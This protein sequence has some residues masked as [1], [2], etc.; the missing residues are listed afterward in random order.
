MKPRRARGLTL[1][2][3]VMVLAVLA[4]LG[5]VALPSLGARLQQQRLGTAAETLVADI[6][7]ARFEA[8][9]QGRAI[10]IVM[11]PGAGWCWSVATTATCPCGQAQA[12]EL[13]SA[14]VA[15]HAGVALVQARTLHLLST[16]QAESPGSAL[17][18]SSSGQQLRVDVQSLGRAR[19]CAARGSSNRYPPC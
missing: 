9:R 3:L 16:G 17:M 15:D 4:V 13:R 12:C 10:H 19:I 6:N 5:A 1:I 11:Q 8:A 2:E 7:E 18:E 14:R